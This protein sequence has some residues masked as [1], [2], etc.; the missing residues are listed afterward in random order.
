MKKLLL[1]CLTLLL[2]V[3]AAWFCLEWSFREACNRQIAACIGGK[4]PVEAFL[5]GR[6]IVPAHPNTQAERQRLIAA[7]LKQNEG[8]WDISFISYKQYLLLRTPGMS[9]NVTNFGLILNLQI[10][11]SQWMQYKT[12]MN[13]TDYQDCLRR[14]Q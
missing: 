4:V 11:G 9:L 12:K 5:E 6:E 1:L 10:T 8:N 14:V 13:K 7:L 2:A 3:A